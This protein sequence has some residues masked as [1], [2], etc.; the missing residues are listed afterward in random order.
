MLSEKFGLK[1]NIKKIE[2]L[3]HANSTRI[4]VEDIMVDGNKLNSVLEFIYFGSTISSSGCIDDEIQ[5]RMAK[6]STSF[7][8]LARDSG[9]TTMC[10]CGLNARYTVQSCCPPCYMEPRHGQCT[11]DR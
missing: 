5:R 3:Y 6:A 8:R 11:D 1:I 7:G 2:V 4:R 9:T 10:P